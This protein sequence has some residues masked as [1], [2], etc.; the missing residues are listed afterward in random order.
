MWINPSIN[1]YTTSDNCPHEWGREDRPS[2]LGTCMYFIGLNED[3]WYRVAHRSDSG[4]LTGSPPLTKC[5]YDASGMT[6]GYCCWWWLP[7]YR[8]LWWSPTKNMNFHQF[9]IIRSKNTWLGQPVS[10]IPRGCPDTDCCRTRWFVSRRKA[11]LR[12]PAVCFTF[13]LERKAKRF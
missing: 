5:I 8:T 9:R 13:C 7:E 3:S 12:K 2:S 4:L 1:N 6:S 11:I 10:G